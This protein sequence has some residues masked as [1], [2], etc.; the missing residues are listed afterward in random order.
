MWGVHLIS[1]QIHTCVIQTWIQIHIPPKTPWLLVIS[2][3]ASLTDIR[4]LLSVSLYIGM[5]AVKS[6]SHHEPGNFPHT[7]GHIIAWI[8][9]SLSSILARQKLFCME[10]I[11]VYYTSSLVNI[12]RVFLVTTE[13]S[14]CETETVNELTISTTTKRL[15]PTG[16]NC[17]E[18]GVHLQPS[19]KPTPPQ[20]C[21]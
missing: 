19:L 1:Q 12:R 13:S 5:L 7:K 6:S 16:A 11:S 3:Q 10:N 2:K 17:K 8:G 20:M 9:D 14:Y 4:D 18:A 21:R 15:F